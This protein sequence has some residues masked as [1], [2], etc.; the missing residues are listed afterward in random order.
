MARAVVQSVFAAL[1]ALISVRGIEPSHR[2]VTPSVIVFRAAEKQQI[3]CEICTAFHARRIQPL[4]PFYLSRSRPE[5]DETV[6]FQR[7][8]PAFPSFS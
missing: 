4:A 2:V 7:P 1:L 3:S 6:L 8:P 5:P